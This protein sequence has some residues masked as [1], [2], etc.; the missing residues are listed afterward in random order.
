MEKEQ[1]D[2]LATVA[3]VSEKMPHPP[4]SNYAPSEVYSTT[5]PPP[6]YMR[7]KSTAVQITRIAAVTLVTMS[8]ILGSFILAASWV[9]ARASCT[10]ESIAAMQAELRLQ[11]QQQQP[12]S[13]TYQQGEFLKH[14]QPEALVQDT[15]DM[16]EVQQSL[17]EQT[18]SKKEVEPDT[19]DVKV[20]KEDENNSKSDNES[21][22]HDDDDDDYD[23][24]EFPPVHIKLPLQFDFDEIAGTLIQE[25]RSRVSC[26][27]ERRRADQVMDGA[28]NNNVDNSTDSRYQRLSGE[29]VA[30]LCES[31][32]P[33]QEQQDQEMLTPI[34]IP[35]GTVQVPLQSQ[36]PNPGYHQYQVHTQYQVPDMQQLPLSDPRGLNHIPPGIVPPELRNIPQVTMEMRPPRMGPQTPMMGPQNPAMGPQVEVRRIPIELRHFSA[37]PM[38]GMR[39]PMPQ[40]PQQVPV[41]Y[42]QV[43]QTGTYGQEQGPAMMPPPAPQ[44]EAQVH[45]QRIIPHVLIPQTEQHPSQMPPQVQ[46]QIQP[47]M[48]PQPQAQPQPQPQPQPQITERQRSPFQGIP[49]EIRRIIQQVPLEIKNIIQ[50]ITGEARPIPVQI[51]EGARRENVQEFK[52]FPEGA[53]PIPLGLPLPLEVRNL[54]EHGNIEGRQRPDGSNEQQEAKPFP[55]PEDDSEEERN[56]PVPAEI[57]NIIHQVVEGNAFPVSRFTLPLRPVESLEIPVEARAE[58][59]DNQSSE[60]ESEQR[61]QE[62]QQT[63]H[64]MMQQ[65]QQQQQQ[66]QQQQQEQEEESRPHYVQPRSVRSIPEAFTHRREKRVRRCACDCAC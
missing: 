20:H 52:P 27:V 62:Q 23:D 46:P 24:D 34:I 49:F 28:N 7:P 65:Q 60:Q 3:V 15:S 13:I 36:E 4:H 66:V 57:R 22:D 61:Q 44:P 30:I 48:Q 19:K 16:K 55:G 40:E 42:Q 1:P 29:R 33:H 9:Q 31:G 39:P 5:E 25:A 26:V 51:P 63:T 32:N 53:Q 50:H 64:M 21:G 56:F 11:Q 35:L 18:P 38:R 17:A 10:P 37:N 47:Q 12:S 58:V 45:E 8:V 14:L 41:M 54:L 43:E 2:S 6:A 59:S